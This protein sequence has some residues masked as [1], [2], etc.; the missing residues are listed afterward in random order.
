MGRLTNI[1]QPTIGPRAETG[2]LRQWCYVLNNALV[3]AG[4]YGLVNVFNH[5]NL[6]IQPEARTANGKLPRWHTDADC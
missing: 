3:G 1:T 2:R 4:F 5:I 6:T